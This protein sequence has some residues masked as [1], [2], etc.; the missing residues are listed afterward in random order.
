MLEDPQLMHDKLKSRWFNLDNTQTGL[1]VE[2]SEE[3]T[4]PE[5]DLFYRRYKIKH[6]ET[7][8]NYKD[9]VANMERLESMQRKK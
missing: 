9:H 5:D 2:F 1:D 3:F 7:T 8:M 6:A 4:D